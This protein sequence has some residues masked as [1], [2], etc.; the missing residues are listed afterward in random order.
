MSDKEFIDDVALVS[1]IF[2]TILV[3]GITIGFI[4]GVIYAIN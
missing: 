1:I 3:A 4:A 2:L